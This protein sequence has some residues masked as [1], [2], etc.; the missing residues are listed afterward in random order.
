MAGES[1]TYTD[2]SVGQHEVAISDLAGNCEVL[3][4][5]SR[6][7][8]VAADQMASVIFAVSCPTP[9]GSI[10]VSAS[11]TGEDLDADGF[12]VVVD[13]GAPAA[14]GINGSMT[15]TGLAPG[16]YAVELQDLTFNCSVNG[17]NPRQVT[18]SAETETPATF[19]VTCRYHLYDRIAYVSLTPTEMMLHSVDPQVPRVVRSLGIEG[20]HPAVS[21]DG[22][23]IAYDWNQDIWVASA[24]GSGAL[25]LTD[26]AQSEEFPAW[27]PN[28]NRLVF[29][30]DYVLW[31]M[32]ADGSNQASLGI[33]GWAPTWSP[34][35]SQISYTSAQGV[36]SNEIWV[37]NADGS[38]PPLNVTNH[39]EWDAH[40]AW[41]PLGDR[42]AFSTARDTHTDVYSVHPSGGFVID[43]TGA[44]V[45]RASSPTW[46]PGAEAIAFQSDA[47]GNEDI[48]YYEQGWDLPVL[49]TDSAAQDIQ[50]SWGGGN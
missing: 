47:G 41:S 21:P 44:T 10:L 46:S 23:R 12:M 39:P 35:G 4:D 3:G 33:D 11:T 17:S 40:P 16:D 15:A 48:M 38:G 1:T 8:S 19:D 30:R 36:S 42:I 32:D 43:M 29:S 25:N 14:I 6:S 28:G 45:T 22:L 2:L 31:T 27:S 50:P 49:L 7:I 9:P 26:N 37:V 5:A 34:D 13:G 24:D 20:E 18:V